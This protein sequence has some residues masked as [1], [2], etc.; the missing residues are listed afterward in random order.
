MS[1]LAAWRT[2]EDDEPAAAADEHGALAPEPYVTRLAERGV[3]EEITAA[4]D[5]ADAGGNPCPN[6]RPVEEVLA[7]LRAIH[8]D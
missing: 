5:I 6:A 4:W 2:F 7:Q 1:P 8:G 3:L